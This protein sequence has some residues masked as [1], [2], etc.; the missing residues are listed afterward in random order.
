MIIVDSLVKTS[1]NLASAEGVAK[2]IK[3]IRMDLEARLG[4]RVKLI[5]FESYKKKT[6]SKLEKVVTEHSLFITK[7]KKIHTKIENLETEINKRVLN[8]D[9]KATTD[10]IWDNFN[11]Y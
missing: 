6:G 2:D 9:F 5:D 4:E 11:N 3:S 10:E 7:M 1:Q 8:T